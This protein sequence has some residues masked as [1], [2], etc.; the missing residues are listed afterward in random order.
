MADRSGNA[1]KIPYVFNQLNRKL[2]RW[3]FRACTSADL[4]LPSFALA[5][6]GVLIEHRG[7]ILSASDWIPEDSSITSLTAEKGL[8]IRYPIR[9]QEDLLPIRHLTNARACSGAQTG[10]GSSRS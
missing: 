9:M 2:A 1:I 8:C 4:K 10:A 3:A 6:D 7:K 5:D